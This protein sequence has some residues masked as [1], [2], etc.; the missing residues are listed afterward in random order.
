MAHE[1]NLK[2][3][4]LSFVETV[5][6]SPVPQGYT[7]QPKDER[8]FIRSGLEKRL[9]WKQDL[10]ILP[11]LALIYFVTYLVSHAPLQSKA[12]S[13]EPIADWG[14]RT[15]TASAMDACWD[16]RKSSVSRTSS[17]QRL[18]NTSVRT[19]SSVHISKADSQ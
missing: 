18:P 15:A 5:N 10:L 3:I 19:P 13:S 6:E 7:L 16:F 1:N 2:D 8:K 11:L 12:T 9:V 4:E 17:I 14:Y